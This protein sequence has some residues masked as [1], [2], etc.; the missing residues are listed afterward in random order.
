MTERASE[1]ATSFLPTISRL[2][3]DE[4]Q[5]A[6]NEKTRPLLLHFFADACHVIFVRMRGHRHSCQNGITLRLSEGW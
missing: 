3:F 2:L 4:I 6:Y 1:H 5:H